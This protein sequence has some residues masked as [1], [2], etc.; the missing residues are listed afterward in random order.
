M[1]EEDLSPAERAARDASW[2]KL[3][4]EPVPMAGDEEPEEE[5][6]QYTADSMY[7]SFWEVA[8]AFIAGVLFMGGLFVL[9]DTP[10]FPVKMFAS[11]AVL[12]SLL[13]MLVR[14]KYHWDA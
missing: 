14:I 1:S 7:Y 6:P 11:A 8:W 9:V 12:F 4:S 2:H 5:G 3:K 10:L 13:I